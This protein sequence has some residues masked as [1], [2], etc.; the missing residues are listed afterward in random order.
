MNPNQIGFAVFRVDSRLIFLIRECPGKS[1]AI[2]TIPAFP[3]LVCAAI[4]KALLKVYRSRHPLQLPLEVL[5]RH[6][7]DP[8]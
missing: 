1:A 4:D 8:Y 3:Q 2:F 6:A 5:H 7:Y